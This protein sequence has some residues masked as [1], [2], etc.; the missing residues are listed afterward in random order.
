MPPRSRPL[1]ARP[2]PS[3]P[4][5][6]ALDESTAK[7]SS[8]LRGPRN[9]SFKY[10][11][12]SVSLNSAFS[13]KNRTVADGLV[14]STDSSN[15]HSSSGSLL[16]NNSTLTNISSS[17]LSQEE[18][19][20]HDTENQ[21]EFGLESE[22]IDYHSDISAQLSASINES[23]RSISPH[24]IH[25]SSSSPIH[26][27]TR[28]S[29]SI[30][31]IELLQDASIEALHHE[32][33]KSVQSVAPLHIGKKKS[34]SEKRPEATKPLKTPS[35]PENINP[36]PNS[37]SNVETEIPNSLVHSF[38]PEKQS[39]DVPYHNKDD[40]TESENQV[41]TY[42]FLCLSLKKIVLFFKKKKKY[43]CLVSLLYM[44]TN[45]LVV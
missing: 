38:M 44:K 28:L 10:Q 25:S 43:K 12:S 2:P 3:F 39:D 17:S 22:K 20:E 30:P 35:T 7:R 41:S 23:I 13:P 45:K 18:Q 33:F 11:P 4:S 31:R 9:C 27:S 8:T 21:L 6:E 42:Y 15:S 29:D 24:Q 5:A 40:H 16:S 32:F 26:N 1:G 34:V 37:K 14:V 19:H 36:Y